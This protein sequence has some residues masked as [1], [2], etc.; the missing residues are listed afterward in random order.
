M[1]TIIWP[2]YID[3][4]HTRSEGRKISLD[5]AVSEP[6]IREITQALKKLRISY[7]VDHSKAY[8]GSWWER[9]GRVVVSQDKRTKLELLRVIA[10]NINKSREN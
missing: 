3:A 4:E 9:S 5:E 10:R 7:N 6:K 1:E 2:V 8:P